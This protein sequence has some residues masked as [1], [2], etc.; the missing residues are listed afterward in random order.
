MPGRAALLGLMGLQTVF[1]LIIGLALWSL[2]GRSTSGFVTFGSDEM[3]LG[4][5]LAAILVVIGA[6]GYYGFPTLSE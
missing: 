5:G 1:F 2:S 6:A 3:L 4:L